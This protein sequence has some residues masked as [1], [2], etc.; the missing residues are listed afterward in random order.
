MRKKFFGLLIVAA[1]MIGCEKKTMTVVSSAVGEDGFIA[2]MYGY[3]DTERLDEAGMPVYSIPFEIKNAPEGTVSFA[4]MMED[5]DAFPV[6]QGFSWIHW[7]AA[8]IKDT[9]IPAGAGSQDA[10]FVQGVNSWWSSLGGSRPAEEVSCYG[11]PA[12]YD[13]K[14]HTYELHVYALDCDLPLENGFLMNELFHSMEGHILAS[15][16]LKAKYQLNR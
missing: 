5:K 16:T 4:L 14:V 10:D 3:N 6:S 9:V 11:G 7:T 8:N 2:D 13:G 12:P 1:L 15:Y